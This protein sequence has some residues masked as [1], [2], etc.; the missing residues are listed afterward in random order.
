MAKC[1]HGIGWCEI[2]SWSGPCLDR[3]WVEKVY[4]RAFEALFGY[5][6]HPPIYAQLVKE[7]G[8]D[9]LASRRLRS[10]KAK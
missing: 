10:A 1:T 5:K 7:R 4:T 6:P 9:P 2:H 8:V 3:D